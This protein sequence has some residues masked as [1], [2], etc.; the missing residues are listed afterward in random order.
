[1]AGDDQKGAA[2]STRVEVRCKG[3]ELQVQV[4]GLGIE[5]ELEPVLVLVSDL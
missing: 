3:G 4:L 2:R 5:H 1:M